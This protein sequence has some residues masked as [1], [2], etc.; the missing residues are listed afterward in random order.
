MR[1]DD[2][3]RTLRDAV[4]TVL[5]DPIGLTLVL[6]ALN[7]QRTATK[8]EADESR[9]SHRPALLCSEFLVVNVHCDPIMT[10]RVGIMR[11]G[12]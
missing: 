7:L 10:F 3:V 9:V 5:G 8:A 6:L 11:K 12:E 1:Y 4:Q 2:R